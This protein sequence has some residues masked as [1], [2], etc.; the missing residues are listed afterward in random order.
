MPWIAGGDFNMITTTTEK[1]GGSKRPDQD[2]EAFGEMILE[3]RLVDIPTINGIHTWKNRR[4]SQNQ[5]ASRPDRFLIS[6]QI[7]NRDIFLETMILPAMGSDHWPIRLEIDIKLSPKRCPFRFEAFWLRNQQFMPKVE[8]WW[9]QSQQR[10]RSKMQ[11]FQ[12]KLK[13]IGEKKM[14]QR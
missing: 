11:T 14:E 5:I 10:G 12:L 2:M 9:T 8:E 3:Q 1:R 4:G 7:I 13:E 6:E